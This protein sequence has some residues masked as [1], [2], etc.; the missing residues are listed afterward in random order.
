[1]PVVDGKRV[2]AKTGIPIGRP[3]AIKPE[4]WNEVYTE[5]KAKKITAVKAMEILG[6]KPNTF[7]KFV[8]QEGQNKK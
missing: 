4:N 7:Y 8:Q 2:S 3:N 6:L 1:M 5:W